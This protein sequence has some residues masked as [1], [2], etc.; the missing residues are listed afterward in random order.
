MDDPLPANLFETDGY[1]VA[2]GIVDCD[3]SKEA[4]SLSCDFLLDLGDRS[5]I[6][7]V[8]REFIADSDIESLIGCRINAESFV[9]S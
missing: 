4:V 5:V 8:D 2:V 3:L 1:V 7:L 6:R 9:F